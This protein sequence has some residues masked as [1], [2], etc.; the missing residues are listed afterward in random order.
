MKL[1]TCIFLLSASLFATTVTTKTVGCELQEN[2]DAAYY[3][4]ENN[5]SKGFIKFI[6]R[7]QCEVLQLDRKV[8]IIGEEGDYYKVTPTNMRELWVRK[9][10]ITK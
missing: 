10:V 6:I 4:W 8:K 2:V 7:N 5:G 1:I 3:L 9:A